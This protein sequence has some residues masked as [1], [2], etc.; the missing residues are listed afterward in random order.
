M[1][2]VHLSET[3][4]AQAQRL[5]ELLSGVEIHALYSSPLERATETAQV[6]G[7]KLGLEVQ[8]R[9]AFG[10][11]R[12]G[13]FS[14]HTLEELEAMRAWK[15]YNSFRSGIRAPGGELVLEVQARFVS[16]LE[17][18]RARH[19]GQ[20]VAIVSHAD[21]I[22]AALAHYMGVPLDLFDRIAVYPASVSMVDIDDAGALIHR[23]NWT[24]S[25][26]PSRRA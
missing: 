7:R 8:L 4:R 10:E 22:K 18:L 3:G 19:P 17:A 1:P 26:R 13:D 23:I 16:E 15:T 21:S 11:V 14:G 20:T 12:F 6:L 25:V 2:G 5:S 9:D 24:E